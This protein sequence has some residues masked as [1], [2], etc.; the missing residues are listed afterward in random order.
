MPS[1]KSAKII[2]PD[3]NHSWSGNDRHIGPCAEE[4]AIRKLHNNLYFLRRAERKAGKDR[5]L[6]CP[7]H[8]RYQLCQ[9]RDPPEPI[10]R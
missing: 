3:D 2:V 8:R 6:F 5:L 7:G 9:L 10:Q 4:Q 1:E